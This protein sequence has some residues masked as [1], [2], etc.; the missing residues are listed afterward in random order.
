MGAAAPHG[1]APRS[2]L[3]CTMPDVS[4]IIVGF[5]AFIW[6]FLRKFEL[7]LDL[8]SS[9]QDKTRLDVVHAIYT[10]DARLSFVV[11]CTPVATGGNPLTHLGA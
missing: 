5:C 10:Q 4:G 7:F 6:V 11:V 9:Q 2:I 8:L 1:K 3:D